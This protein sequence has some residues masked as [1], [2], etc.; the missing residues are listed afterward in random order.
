LFYVA[1]TR[2]REELHLFAAPE[3][4]ANGSAGLA[5]GSLLS[6]AW[7]A[8]E[9]HFPAVR[10]DSDGVQEM[11]VLSNERTPASSVADELAFDIAAVAVKEQP[12][13]LERLPLS[14]LSGARFAEA[15]K[16]PYGNAEAETAATHF[17]RPEGSFE[18]RAF[19][20]AVH[21]FLELAAKELARGANAEEMLKEVA[22]WEQRILAVLR[23]DGLAAAQAE[24]LASRVKP[25][26]ENTLRDAEGLWILGARNQA[27]SEFALTSWTETRRSVRLDRVFR[28]GTMPLATGDECLWIVD[29]KTTAH[30][31]EGVEEFL[32]GERAKYSAQ[33][34]AYALMMK[35]AAREVR[36]GLYYPMLPRFVWWAP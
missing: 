5:Y 35:D 15:R 10:A 23:G 6:A 16:L 13:M 36:V 25:A 14:Y 4:K 31:T 27:S 3:A 26:L 20:N 8:A 28:G 24:Q 33:M 22:G 17:E 32:A 2:A 18:A 12:A 21:A 34:E 7:P 11:P 9:R 29:Y 30:G 1:C 19:G